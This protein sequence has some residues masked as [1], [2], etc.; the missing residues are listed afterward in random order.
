[1]GYASRGQLAPVPTWAQTTAQGWEG[2]PTQ[3]SDTGYQFPHP[4]LANSPSLYVEN[5]SGDPS[6]V[7][8]GWGNYDGCNPSTGFH[9]GEQSSYGPEL[10]FLAKYRAANPGVPMASIKVV[11]G[12]SSIE[13]WLPGTTKWQ[14][15]KLHLDQAKVRFTN[16]GITPEW[17]GF[18]WNQGENGASTT[19][20]YLHPTPGQEFSDKTRTFIAAVRA[21]TSS[22]MPV[23]LARISANMLADNIILP[24]ATGGTETVENVRGATNY[25][26]AQQELVASDPGNALADSDNLP[27]WQNGDPRYWYHYTGAGYLALGERYYTAFA[28]ATP[29]PPPPPALVVKFNGQAKPWTVKLNGALIGAPGDTIDVEGTP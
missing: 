23:V 16:A 22:Q 1:M 2:H 19:W 21:E 7:V 10:S 24:L 13:E 27:V 20:P 14:V 28:G 26:R 18:F 5:N 12:G 25:R 3:S 15:L 6:L 11:V 8:D 29:P 9:A 17:A 4:T